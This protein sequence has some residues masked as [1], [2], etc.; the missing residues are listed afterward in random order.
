M[1]DDEK[2]HDHKKQAAKSKG[3]IKSRWRKPG[4]IIN[5][6]NRERGESFSIQVSALE[7]GNFRLSKSEFYIEYALSCLMI[8][9]GHAFAEKRKKIALREYK[10]LLKKT[11]EEHRQLQSSKKNDRPPLVGVSRVS[12]TAAI[13]EQVCI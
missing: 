4:N 13:F 1:A 9:V 3:K 5:M 2:R 10:K 7:A 12:D 8:F 11:R 6:G